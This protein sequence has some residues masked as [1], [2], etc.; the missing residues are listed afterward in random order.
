M[1]LVVALLALLAA[2]QETK[3]D[4]VLD[5]MEKRTEGLQDLE[6]KVV[7]RVERSMGLPRTDVT[8]SWVRGAGL[9]V[10]ARTQ[11]GAEGRNFGVQ[12][13]R[14]ADY[15]YTPD[16]FRLIQEWD[17]RPQAGAAAAFQ[18]LAI[19]TD[20]PAL[21]SHDPLLLPTTGYPFR[22]MFDEP[23]VYTQMAPRLLLRMEPNLALEGKR[24]EG[25]RTFYL[26]VSTPAPRDP[27]LPRPA[28]FVQGRRKQF[29]VDARTG[30]LLKIRWEV[31]FSFNIGGAGA[32]EQRM[33]I[34]SEAEG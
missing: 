9:R 3:L 26:L 2:P 33:T 7:T 16:R 31:T 14:G 12:V 32:T 19:R 8:V 25:S 22:M 23:V 13:P 6:V 11:M 29:F 15:I 28:Y 1:R 34:V 10:H 18:A 4:E 20:D 21:R 27:K 30:C 24:T 17:D 5:L